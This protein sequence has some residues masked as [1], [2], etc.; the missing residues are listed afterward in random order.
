MKITKT[1]LIIA[2]AL[3]VVLAAT[4]TR[5]LHQEPKIIEKVIKVPKVVEKTVTLYKPVPMPIQ[6]QP[7]MY[8]SL[9]ERYLVESVVTAEAGGET[10]AGQLLVAQCIFNAC[11]KSKLQPSEV[12][13]V[14]A[15]TKHRP[16]PVES[17][18]EAVRLV[19]D[20]GVELTTE[21]ILYFYAP[22]LVQSDW[23]ESQQFVLEL[24]GH[25]FFKEADNE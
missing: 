3:N 18:R 23:H 11:V 16:E 22:A 1:V 13:E 17:A 19:F 14:Y 24:G 15:Y 25:R 4:V 9:E 20:L 7:R 6:P 12:F 21:P 10:L 2:L 8:L 5:L